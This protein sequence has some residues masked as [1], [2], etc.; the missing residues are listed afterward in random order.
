MV[1][2]KALYVGLKFPLAGVVE[3]KKT[4]LKQAF[5]PPGKESAN[6]IA[7]LCAPST[8]EPGMLSRDEC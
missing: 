6:C 1:C 5:P 2:R 4:L 8:T 3:K 7:A